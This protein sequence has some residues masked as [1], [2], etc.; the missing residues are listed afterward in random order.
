[1]HHYAKLVLCV[2]RTWIQ[3]NLDI[4]NEK[5]FLNHSKLYIVLAEKLMTCVNILISIVVASNN[6][7]LYSTESCLKFYQ[8]NV[9]I[10]YNCV[11]S[12]DHYSQFKNNT[13]QWCCGY[14]RKIPLRTGHTK[15]KRTHAFVRKMKLYVLLS[16]YE[17]N[18]T[19]DA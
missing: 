11:H 5:N 14:H 8:S 4:E 7:I 15:E 18:T 16:C 2:A 12:R 6:V 17:E 1:M 13:R 3:L 19:H 9:S 10:W